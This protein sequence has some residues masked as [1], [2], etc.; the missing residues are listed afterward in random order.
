MSSIDPSPLVIED[1]VVTGRLHRPGDLARLLLALLLLVSIASL[2]YLAQ[3]TTSGLDEDITKGANRLPAALLI[4]ASL[5]SGF[6]TLLFP[7]VAAID[8]IVRRRPRQFIESISALLTTLVMLS[9]ASWVLTTYGNS[10]LLFAFAGP[11]ERSLAAPLNLVL[12]GLAAF[13]T[14]ARLMSR[15]RWQAITVIVLGSISLADV[16]S[17]GITPAGLGVSAISG[18][19]I[20]LIIRYFVGTDSTRPSGHDIAQTLS[21]IGHPIKLLRAAET[22]RAGRRY[23]ATTTDGVKLD[24]IVLDRDLEGAGLATSI[25]RSLRLRDDPSGNGASM[26]RRLDRSALISWAVEAAGINSPRLLSAADVGPDATL[27]VYE[28]VAGRTFA[29]MGEELNNDH[30]TRAWSIV[31]DLQKSQIVHR[32][33]TGKHFFLS[34]TGQVYLTGMEDGVIA[35]SDVLLRID[36]AEALC[37]LA[38]L[39]TPEEAI[40]AGRA[41]LGDKVL[42]RALPALQPVA[43][44]STTR[45]ALKSDRKLLGNLRSALAAMLP[46]GTVEEVDIERIKPRTLLTIAAGTIAGYLLLSQ[47]TRVNIVDLFAQANLGWILLGLALSATTYFAAALV[48]VGIIPERLSLWKTFQAQ[49]AATF[50]TLVAPPTIGSFTVNF[51]FLVRQGLSSAVSAASVAVSQV[52]AVFSHL[53]LLLLALVV[54][55]TSSELAFRPPKVA[56][57]VAVVAILAAAGALTVPSVRR[58]VIERVSPIIQ[59]VIPRMSALASQPLK[60][61]TGI[62]GVALLNVSYCMCLV[63]SVRAFSPQS[64]VAAISL[65]YLTASVIA[66]AAPTPGGLGAVE[67]A[68]AAGLTATGID[69]AVA[70]SATLLYRVLTFWIPALPGWLAFTRLQKAGDL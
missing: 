1:S 34:D 11:V 33:L 28:Y 54:A 32:S 31:A 63:S 55:G 56:I 70:V 65:V 19:A 37:T 39:S 17:G 59:Q 25:Y 57:I 21:R 64:S 61:G 58:R 52:L 6:G 15:S 16:I 8:L 9:L 38:A 3:S 30:I 68:L 51:R 12:G 5:V 50:A 2:A 41:V 43:L 29:A 35:A 14:V 27:L 53:S 40:A 23:D 67:A 42:A 13:V 7:A 46:E 18:W 26:R 48:L 20:G 62:F 69:G 4:A 36:L 44:S 47:L 66:Q 24:L 60:L 10:R 45:T 49:L 22:I